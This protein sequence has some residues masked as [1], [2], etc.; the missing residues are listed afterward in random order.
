MTTSMLGIY[1]STRETSIYNIG[2]NQW[3]QQRRVLRF[4]LKSR[5]QSGF[6][7]GNSAKTFLYAK[8]TADIRRKVKNP[9]LKAGS[10]ANHGSFVNR[11]SLSLTQACH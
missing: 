10:Q 7:T 5:P 8:L 4:L 3:R 1:A 6:I 11:G 2:G 9:S